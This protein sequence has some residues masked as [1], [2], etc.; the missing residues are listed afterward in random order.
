MAENAPMALGAFIQN[1]TTGVSGATQYL[2][3]N[4][5][6]GNGLPSAETVDAK[7]YSPGVTIGIDGTQKA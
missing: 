4:L 7:F 6:I 1:N 3:P 5:I 2:T